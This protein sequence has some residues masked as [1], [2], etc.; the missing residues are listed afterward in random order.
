MPDDS[1]GDSIGQ[2]PAQKSPGSEPFNSPAPPDHPPGQAAQGV[3][4]Q[5]VQCE[6]KHIE[7]RVKRAERWMIGLTAAIVFWGFCAVIVGL[8][9]WGAMKRQLSMMR[10]SLYI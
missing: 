3:S 5:E 6:V 2:Q 8:L 10:L 4:R 7:D 1:P 9:Q